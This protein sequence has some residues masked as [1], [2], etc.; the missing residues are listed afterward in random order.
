MKFFRHFLRQTRCTILAAVI[1]ASH[2]PA[3]CAADEPAATAL[4]I[5]VRSAQQVSPYEAFSTLVPTTIVPCSVR[6]AAPTLK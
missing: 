1:L 2:L 4:K 3:L 6:S 5:A